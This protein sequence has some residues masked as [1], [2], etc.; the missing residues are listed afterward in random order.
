MGLAH[1]VLSVAYPVLYVINTSGVG[2]KP[3]RVADINLS[4]PKIEL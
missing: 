3:P 1:P 2:A 4:Y